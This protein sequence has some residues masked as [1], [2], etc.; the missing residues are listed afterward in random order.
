MLSVVTLMDLTL[1]HVKLDILEMAKVAMVCCSFVLL[2][3]LMLCCVFVGSPG[4]EGTP[5]N[6]LYREA[7]PERGTF[8]FLQVYEKVGIS[9]AKVYKRVGK[10]V[11]KVFKRTFN[12]NI[13][14][15]RPLWLYQFIY[16]YLLFN[17]QCHCSLSA[18][19]H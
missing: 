2:K 13:M 7:P 1:A 10:S 3:G 6:D 12:Y 17:T 18:L 16:G 11:I 14:N 9:Q 5:Y 8:F 4:E 15:R 19:N